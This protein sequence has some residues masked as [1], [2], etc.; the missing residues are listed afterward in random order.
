[1]WY[2]EY[3]PPPYKKPHDLKKVWK[4][5]VLAAVIKHMS[6]DFDRIRGLVKQS[7]SLQGKMTAKDT[8]LWS[9]VVNNQEDLA[10]L[11]PQHVG[12]YN[13]I[14]DDDEKS[15]SK[16][17]SITMVEMI[18]NE[19]SKKSELYSLSADD[20]VNSLGGYNKSCYL[21]EIISSE[22]F[23]SQAPLGEEFEAHGIKDVDSSH[24]IPL[25]LDDDHNL[26][27][28]I[29]KLWDFES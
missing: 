19:G 6:P 7:K 25:W 4:V 12:L 29:T 5:S 24:I 17:D 8:A 10:L 16:I 22:D 21:E 20:F 14:G 2:G 27:D 11:V 1:M 15:K 28:A 3:G 26:Q 23:I 9:K 18:A 13:N